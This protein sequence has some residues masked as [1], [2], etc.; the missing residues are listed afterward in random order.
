MGDSRVPLLIDRRP[1][2]AA[3]RDEKGAWCFAEF[4]LVVGPKGLVIGMASGKVGAPGRP[5]AEAACSARDTLVASGKGIL[6]LWL[7]RQQQVAEELLAE[8]PEDTVILVDDDKFA[9][10]DEAFLSVAKSLGFGL[11]FGYLWRADVDAQT[12]GN[13]FQAALGFYKARPWCRFSGD[14]LPIT[15]PAGDI[16]AYVCIMG[17]EGISRG[18]AVFY[19]ERDLERALN[20]TNRPTGAYTTFEK[21]KEVPPPMLAEAERCGW[22]YANKSAFPCMLCMRSGEPR[23]P[24]IRDVAVATAAF[25]AF[26]GPAAKPPASEA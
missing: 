24:E 16:A 8:F 2:S 7:A 10:W 3:Y 13:M 26:G 25:S 5:A 23:A 6:P 1:T 21:I 11:P 22:R 9:P 17:Q 19:T 4:A 15:A 20:G 12:V 14:P 18:I